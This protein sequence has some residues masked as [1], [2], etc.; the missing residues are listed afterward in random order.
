[1]TSNST[2]NF[3]AQSRP[4]YLENLKKAPSHH[5]TH[6]KSLVAGFKHGHK[7]WQFELEQGFNLMFYGFGSK[8]EIL[9][10]FVDFL[11]GKKLSFKLQDQLLP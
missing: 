2:L 3:T 4:E 11:E 7:Q 1:V 6:F 9:N 5:A 8:R 10:D